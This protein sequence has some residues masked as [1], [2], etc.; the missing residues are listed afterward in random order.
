MRAIRV[1][2]PGGP[3]KLMLEDTP[4]P[5][6]KPGELLVKV[7]AAGVN[8]IDI[9][10]RTGLYPIPTPFT[11][12][13]EGAGTVEA[14][15][16]EVD[17]IKTGDRVTWVGS[18]CTYAEYA[19]VPAGIALPIP[20]GV[21]PK[22]AAASMLQGMTAHYLTHSTYGL[23][24][25]DTCLVHAAAGGTGLLITQM[26][27]RLGARVIGTTSTQ[28]KADAARKAGADEMILYTE[29]DFATEAKRLSDG[30]GVDVVYDSV[31]KSTWERSLNSLRPRGTMV[32]F[33]NASGPVDPIAP[34][35]LS[36]KGSLFLTRP[37]LADY[38]AAA[39]E[40]RWRGGD[41]LRWVASGE[42]R[43]KVDREYGLDQA[44]QAHE[45]LAS[46]STSGKLLLLP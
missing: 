26:A 24:Q 42:L 32:S 21:E 7:A 18:P 34:L 35:V 8:F 16:A 23:K 9:Y 14:V 2:Q 25:G 12:G 36:Q 40:L 4:V 17:F 5:Q 29:Q 30:R 46:R 20:P 45:D 10:Q 6:P 11:P 28:E 27:K 22:V 3:D 15:G 19:I 39:D 13:Q 43:I 41:V 31:G 44:G 37:K 33:G 38:T 1:H